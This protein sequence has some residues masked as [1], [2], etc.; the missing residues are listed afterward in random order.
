MWALVG[1]IVLVV[2]IHVLLGFIGYSKLLR[3]VILVTPAT[4]LLFGLAVQ[5]LAGR[6][7]PRRALIVGL[8]AFLMVGFVLEVSQGIVTPLL[9]SDFVLIR[10]LFSRPPPVPYAGP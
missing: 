9:D 6:L 2:G 10:P 1:W 7:A 5:E 8:F 4:V 3:Y